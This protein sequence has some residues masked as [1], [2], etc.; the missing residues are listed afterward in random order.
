MLRYETHDG[1]L[2]TLN[3]AKKLVDVWRPQGATVVPPALVPGCG[4]RERCQHIGLC[5]GLI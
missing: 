5:A 1:V 3:L 2:V 4:Q